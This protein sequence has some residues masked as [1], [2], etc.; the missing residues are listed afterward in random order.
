MAGCAWLCHCHKDAADLGEPEW[1]AALSIVGRCATADADGRILA[2]RMSVAYPR[3]TPA[4]TDA[5]LVQALT[6]AGPRTC[7]DVAHH[8][9]GFV[10]F[11]SKCHH[12][13]R[14]KSPILLGRRVR[15]EGDGR[16]PV[17]LDT[18]E[19]EVND[20]ALAGL[21]RHLARPPAR[22]QRP[23]RDAAPGDLVRHRQ[24]RHPHRRPRAAAS[25]SVSSPP[26]SAPRSAPASATPAS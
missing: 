26:T 8:R 14:I 5:K 22:H 15:G 10:P 20:Q 4:E 24:Q 1:F 12:F 16:M 23:G 6:S 19:H 2:H 3:Y 18:R 13:G 11:C 25:T 7:V 9:G 17:I 21:A